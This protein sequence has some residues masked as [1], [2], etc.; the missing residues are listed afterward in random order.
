MSRQQISELTLTF[1]L[2][3]ENKS[4]ENIPSL[5]DQ[6]TPLI[7]YLFTTPLNHF[8]IIKQIKQLR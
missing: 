3:N 8:K 4:D 5:P 7:N 6:K 2:K 1:V